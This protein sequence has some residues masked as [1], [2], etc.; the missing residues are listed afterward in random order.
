M[1]LGAI[2]PHF[3]VWND[4]YATVHFPVDRMVQKAGRIVLESWEGTRA[5]R[6]VEEGLSRSFSACSGKHHTSLNSTS[7]SLYLWLLF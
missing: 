4:F 5:S 7:L 2:R 1:R 6:R 3:V